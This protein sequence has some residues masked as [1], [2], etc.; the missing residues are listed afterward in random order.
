[1]P[2]TAQQFFEVFT[3][4]N[5]FIFP[6]Q[7]ALVWA[8]FGAVL[9][10]IS[11]ERRAGQIISGVLAFLWLWAGIVYHLIFFTRI[12]SG[13]YIFGA[14]FVAEGVFLIYEGIVNK[15]LDFRFKLE[16]DTVCGAVLMTYALLIY[17][18]TG[19]LLGRVFPSS[20]TFGAPCP[21]TIFTFGLLLWAGR[22]L[23]LYLLVLPLLWAV[24]G[25]TAT[26]HF[27]IAE[28]FGL[29]VAALVTGFLVFR[30]Q[31]EPPEEAFYEHDFIKNIGGRGGS[32]RRPRR[33]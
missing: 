9:L 17:P 15:R 19:Y 27:G 8:A 1:M 31:F 4:Y 20:P 29:P 22:S 18:V 28:D 13:A 7:F 5:Q 33:I 32:R 14:M 10:A 25:S 2:F 23:P 12:N 3:Q 21:T 6:M 11:R 24:I 26:W 16:A 30:R